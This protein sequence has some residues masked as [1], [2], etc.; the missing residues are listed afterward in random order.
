MPNP[1]NQSL[2]SGMKALLVDDDMILQLALFNQLQMIGFEVTQVSD[3]NP[4]IEQI[5]MA[6]QIGA[7]FKLAFF[8]TRMPTLNGPDAVKKL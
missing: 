2:V 5:S 3:G 8:D 1:S 6:E 7:P 4:A